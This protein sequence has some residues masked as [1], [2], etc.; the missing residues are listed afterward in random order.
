[1]TATAGIQFLVVSGVALIAWAVDAIAVS[2]RRAALAGIP[3][4]TLYLVPATVLPDGVPWP[5]FLAA[6]IGWLLLLLED[7]RV[8]LSRWGR[9]I[10]GGA[11]GKVHSVGGTGR[12]LGAAALTV[13]VIVP[14]ILPSL[15]DGRFGG[16]SGD[17][18]GGDG[19]GASSP[20]ARTVVTINPITDLQRNLTQQDDSAVL[21]YTTAA[22][23]PQYLRIATLDKFNGTTWTLEEMAA[24]SDQQASGGSTEPPWAL[25]RNRADAG[26][27]RHHRRGSRHPPTATPLSGHQGRYRRRLEVGRADLR[28][29]QRRGGGLGFWSGVHRDRS[30]DHAHHRAVAGSTPGGPIGQ[31]LASTN[32]STSPT[33][34]R[35]D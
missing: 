8:E 21:F 23:T 24:G 18:S 22:Q 34:S 33:A 17:G 2:G 30:G 15:G 7:G 9:P 32:G 27:L 1:M 29:L 20:S 26:E 4:L 12:R 5:L 14:V 16:G 35:S 19:S 31:Q 28:R 11:D 6:G 13:A 10:D 25:R 3:L